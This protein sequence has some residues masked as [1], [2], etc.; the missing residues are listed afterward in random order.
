[1]ELRNKMNLPNEQRFEDKAIWCK[2]CGQTFVFTAGEQLFYSDRGL[3]EPRRC[4]DCRRSHRQ[5]INE[6]R[7][8]EK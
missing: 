8:V 5:P 3:A 1:M 2:V 4:P 6:K 7:G